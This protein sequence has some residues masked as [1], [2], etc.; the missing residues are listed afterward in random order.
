M[1]AQQ[2]NEDTPHKAYVAT[3]AKMVHKNMLLIPEP[4]FDNYVQEHFALMSRYKRV[5][6]ADAET[7][8]IPDPEVPD[9]EIA[10]AQEP[11]VSMIPSTQPITNTQPDLFE[12]EEA[13]Q[14]DTKLV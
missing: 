10:A 9:P 6:Q 5:V 8:F 14:S 13:Q 1:K 4:V 7:Y 12:E 11:D 2:E 3:V